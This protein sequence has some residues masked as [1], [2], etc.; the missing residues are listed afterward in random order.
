[1]NQLVLILT[2]RKQKD[3][4]VNIQLF[5]IKIKKVY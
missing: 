3:N 4:Q 5:Q 1:M 2:I